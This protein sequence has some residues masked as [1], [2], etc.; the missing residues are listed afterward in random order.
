MIEHSKERMGAMIRYSFLAAA[1]VAAL[2]LAVSTQSQ[3]FHG[4]F[5]FNFGFGGWGGPFLAYPN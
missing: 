1:L 5:S 2:A 4:F 3:A